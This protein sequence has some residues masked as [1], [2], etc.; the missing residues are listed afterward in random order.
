MT[1]IN[2]LFSASGCTD[3]HFHSLRVPVLNCFATHEREQ[4]AILL[5]GLGDTG[6]DVVA[7]W[8]IKNG[9]E[10]I[11]FE[12]MKAFIEKFKSTSVQKFGDSALDKVLI[13]NKALG[14]KDKVQH[15]YHG[16]EEKGIT[17]TKDANITDHVFAA[18][19]D[20]D[21][22][23]TSIMRALYKSIEVHGIDVIMLEVTKPRWEQNPGTVALEELLGCFAVMDALGY[24]M[25]DFIPSFYY[26][27]NATQGVVDNWGHH[28]NSFQWL[29]ALASTC[30][31]G[32]PCSVWTDIVFVK[33]D[34][35]SRSRSCLQTLVFEC[36][37]KKRNGIFDP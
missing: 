10:L 26:M 9:R 5:V 23:H 2:E 12:V 35:L 25:F 17:I 34:L 18:S 6:E 37:D 13:H 32:G 22:V 7:D 33:R 36:R 4:N 11:V 27:E 28:R 19:I 1:L 20:A 16:H 14:M 15:S 30:E 8:S 31:T 3:R 24:E 29:R 21:G